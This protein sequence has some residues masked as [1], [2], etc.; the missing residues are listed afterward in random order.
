MKFATMKAEYVRPWSTEPAIEPF[1][2]GFLVLVPSVTSSLKGDGKKKDEEY[3]SI[4]F[5]LEI[6]L[7]RREYGNR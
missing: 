1:H 5:I 2:E 3:P 6:S 7:M 4:S